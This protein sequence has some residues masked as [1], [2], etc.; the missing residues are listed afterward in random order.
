VGETEP[1]NEIT[2]LNLQSLG[3]LAAFSCV[4]FF[5]LKT[6]KSHGQIWLAVTA[7][8][9]LVLTVWAILSS[10][11]AR[12]LDAEYGFSIINLGMRTGEIRAFHDGVVAF[13]I[14]V[15]FDQVPPCVNFTAALI[16]IPDADAEMWRERLSEYLKRRWKQYVIV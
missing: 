7:T 5:F 11:R 15:D 2:K 12:R 14:P 6:A 8:V 13:A 16:D 4:L 10:R 3:C 1:V 9:I